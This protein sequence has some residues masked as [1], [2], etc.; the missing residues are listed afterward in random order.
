MVTLSWLFV[1]AAAVGLLLVSW[2]ALLVARFMRREPRVPMKPLQGISILKPMVGLDD[3]LEGNLNSFAELDYPEC[4]VLIGFES[5]DA[6][7]LP[8]ARSFVARWPER[9][10]IFFQEGQPGFNPKVN[11]LITLT[12]HARYG[13]V[14]VNDAS[15]RVKPDY[16]HEISAHFE[17]EDVALVFHPVVGR[18]ERTAGSF[19]DNLYITIH[20]SAGPIAAKELVDEDL[21]VGK[22]MAFRRADLAALGGFESVKDYL[23]EDYVMGRWIKERLRKRVAYARTI[24]TTV[25]QSKSMA[26]YFHRYG[27]WAVLQRHAVGVPTYIGKMLMYPTSFAAVAFV[28]NPGWLTFEILA[29]IGT[30]K[31]LLEGWQ[32]RMFRPREFPLWGFALAPIH[33]LLVAG[34]WF[35]GLRYNRVEWRGRL[36][37]VTTG[38]RL[39]AIEGTPAEHADEPLPDG[40]GPHPLTR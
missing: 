35:H 24:V 2:Q 22:S 12:R 11:Q 39:V 23:A 27:R 20:S 25:S 18:G 29:G 33:D 8:L 28:L 40:Q 19:F 30:A 32:M 1:L 21:T 31:A 36:L 14:V 34:A 6:A 37:E 4:E 10:R 17:D 38:S 16:L 26:Q 15:V 9:F 7:A 5:E 13:I 3:G